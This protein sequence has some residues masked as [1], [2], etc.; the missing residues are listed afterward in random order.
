MTDFNN[1]CKKG[2]VVI[3]VADFALYKERVGEWK[4][5]DFSKLFWE[6]INENNTD[7]FRRCCIRDLLRQNSSTQ[8]ENE[9]ICFVSSNSFYYIFDFANKSDKEGFFW[10]L[11]NRPKL[12]NEIVEE[13]VY[14]LENDLMQ[15]KYATYNEGLDKLIEFLVCFVGEDDGRKMFA[16]HTAK[17]QKVEKRLLS[18]CA[19]HLFRLCKSESRMPEWL[20]NDAWTDIQN[21]LRKD[22]A[23]AKKIEGGLNSSDNY[24][25]W[26]K[27]EMA[28]VLMDFLSKQAFKPSNDFSLAER[29]VRL[30]EYEL[31]K[32]SSMTYCREKEVMCLAVRIKDQDLALRF[33][34]RHT[35]P[36]YSSA[37]AFLSEYVLN[38]SFVYW[39]FG[40]TKSRTPKDKELLKLISKFTNMVP[41]SSD[42]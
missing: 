10:M 20:R 22:I 30:F 26:C 8:S 31:G 7:S 34:R 19:E 28:T 21:W 16:F 13:F 12:L 14:N 37:N 24:D 23:S 41:D 3:S 39:L 32:K 18:L 9:N 1:F 6:W 17:N 29:C 25:L 4:R 42:N 11:K 33:A 5:D 35:L 40:I 38:A 27:L 36:V 15:S 2:P